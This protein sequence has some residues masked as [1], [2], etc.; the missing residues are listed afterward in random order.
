MAILEFIKYGDYMKVSAID[1]ET[2][3]EAL[4]ILPVQLSQSDMKKLAMKKLKYVME[5]K[6]SEDGGGIIA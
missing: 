1:E 5:K 2:G 3:I 6:R 4:S